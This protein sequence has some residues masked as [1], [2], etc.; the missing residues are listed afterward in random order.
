MPGKPGARRN[1][2]W[3]KERM[4]EAG[5]RF[6]REH[7]CTPTNEGWWQA[8]TQFTAYSSDGLSNHGSNRPYPS[9]G[10]L[11]NCWKGTR[12]F[13]T[14]VAAAYPKLNILLD[15]GDAPWSPLEEWFIAETVGLISRAEVARLMAESG[16]GRTEAAIKRRLYEMGINT[17]NRWGWTVHHLSTV[18]GVSDA[19]IGNYIDHGRLPFFQGNNCLYIEPADFFIIQEYNWS[20]KH[21][22][23]ELEEAV[24]KS[25]MQ[26]LCF[27]LLRLEWR[28][29]SYHQIQARREFFTGQVKKAR[30]RTGPTSEPKPDHVHIGDWVAI[31]GA[32]ARMPGAKGRIGSVKNIVW[33]PQRS[34]ATQ[35]HPAR[36]ACWV[37]VIEFKKMKAHGRPEYPRVRYNVP[38]SAVEKVRKPYEKK[39]VLKPQRLRVAREL[40]MKSLGTQVLNNRL[41]VVRK[42]RVA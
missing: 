40:R 6:Y 33:T 21:H 35:K 5:A 34:R 9:T 22:P 24:R 36:P 8:E 28:K 39:R 15:K 20:K 31:T 38:A 32:W 37:V 2:W 41:N 7:K 11:K 29:F 10:P 13:W 27:I 17:Y 14:A 23:R 30:T 19:V 4:L 1:R 26:R 25:L 42:E 12:D 3:T 18:I 16:L